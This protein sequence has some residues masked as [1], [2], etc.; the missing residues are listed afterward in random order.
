MAFKS[1]NTGS[2]LRD[3][4]VAPSNSTTT[5]STQTGV[6]RDA[7]PVPPSYDLDTD[8]PTFVDAAACQYLSSVVDAPGPATTEYLVWSTNT[9][10]LAGPIDPD[11]TW[12]SES[13]YGTIPVGSKT[14]GVYTDGSERAVVTDNGFRDIGRIYAIV[15]AR[16][17][18]TNYDDDGWKNPDDTNPASYSGQP[19]NGL[20]PFITL[21][22][23]E[24]EQ[25]ARLGVVYF[26]AEHL[27]ALGGGLSIQRGDKIVIV[28]YT[29]DSAKFWWTKN[30][31]YESRFGWVP[32]S[33][34]WEPFK[35]SAPVMLGVVLEDTTYNM[36]PVIRNLPI[37]SLL[38]GN[39]NVSD[40]Y[41]MVR[42]G[43]VPSASE[44]MPVGNVIVR[45]DSELGDPITT[46]GR[47]SQ[48]TGKLELSPKFVSTHR[49]KML[50]YIPNTFV[51]VN[52]GVIGKLTDAF[53]FIA[54]IPSVTEFPLIRFGSRR[55]LTPKMVT[56]DY[57]LSTMVGPQPGNVLVSAT[58]GKLKLSAA[59]VA[60]S[61]T[62]SLL[63][64][65]HFLGE[66]V[67]Y[68]GVSLSGKPQPV[69]APVQLLDDIGN[70]ATAASDEMYIPDYEYLPAEFSASNTRRGLGTSGILDA[71]DGT[72]ANPDKPG[73]HAPIRP[74]G[75]NTIDDTTGRVR[76]VGDGISDTI[77]FTQL[78]SIATTKV[79]NRLTDVPATYKIPSGTAYI[80][81]ER[82][83]H[84]SRVV[85]SDPDK[86][87][88]GTK[89]IFFL[90]SAFNPA[91]HTTHARLVS[92]NRAIFRLSGTEILRFAIDG[93]AHMWSATSLV[94][95][96]PAK[97]FFTATDIT[98]NI[99]MP[100][101][102]SSAERIIIE[103]PNLDS[104]S[105]EIGFG[106]G[107]VLDTSGCT[108]LGFVPG[109]RAV[110]GVDNWLP[111]SGVSIGMHR[112]PFNTNGLGGT[113]DFR[114]VD[115]V[116]NKIL[117]NGVQA[118]PFYFL[119]T[120]PLQDIA[121]IDDGVFFN[122]ST[123]VTIDDTVHAV[124]RNLIHYKDIVH[125][126]GH[127]KF[128][129]VDVNVVDEDIVA[130]TVTINFGHPGVIPESLESAV[131]G[132]LFVSKDGSVSTR[133]TLDVD[134][135][136]Q[137]GGLSGTALLTTKF[138][139]TKAYGAN[140]SILSNDQ[141]FSDPNSDFM[142]SGAKSGDIIVIG[143]GVHTVVDVVDPVTLYVTPPPSETQVGV[144]WD[145]MS[146][147]PDSVYDPAIVA[148]MSYTDFDH[149]LSE[150]MSIRILSPVD[151]TTGQANM[152][153]ALSSK[154]PMSIRFGSE[155]A[156]ATNT[157]GL[158]PLKQI[159][160]G[161]P[162][163]G[164]ILP[165]SQ[166]HRFDTVAFAIRA[167]NT[168]YKPIGVTNFS[169]DPTTIE[170]L[171]IA[172]VG[173]PCGTIK[174]GS[175]FL[176]S[177]SKVK[178]YYVETFLGRNF[179][180]Y[181]TA[182][183]D[184]LTGVINPSESDITI[185]SGKK[186]Y[187][188]EQLV[189]TARKDVAINPM[190]GAFSTNQQLTAGSLVE[191][192]YWQ[193]DLEGRKVGGQTTELLSVFVR[194][195]VAKPTQTNVYSFNSSRT[196]V[197]DQS[198]EPIVYIGPI[199]QNF[200]RLDYTVDYP[201]N[202]G[203]AGRITFVSHTVPNNVDVK[204][205]YSVFD[206]SGGERSFEVSKKPVY[207]PPFFIGANKD[208][209]GLRGNRVDE[210]M[211]GQLIR[212]GDECFYVKSVSYYQQNDKG[213]GDVTSV[214]I[215]PPTTNEVGSRAPGNDILTVITKHPITTMV[216]PDG[217]N[218]VS[219]TAPSG[220]MSAIDPS[221]LH[222]D[223]IVPGHKT[224][225]VHGDLSF[226]KPGRILEIGGI[227]YTISD[228]VVDET[229][230]RT[231]LT[232]TAS[233]RSNISADDE[234]TFKVSN[235]PV[236]P[237]GATDFLGV[238]PILHTDTNAVLLL[239][240]D[241]PGRVLT[242]DVDYT[243]NESTGDVSI[244]SGIG[245]N[246]KVLVKF[247]RVDTLAPRM[248]RGVLSVPRF[249]AMFLSQ[250]M[251]NDENGILG[252]KLAAT[253]TYYAP[254]SFYFRAVPLVSF[255]GEVVTEVTAEINGRQPAG[256][257]INFS[258]NGLKNWE[259][260][261]W[262]ILGE[263]RHLLD[264]DR[265]SRTFLEY[266]N[267]VIVS[268]EQ[269][270]ETI[271]GGF[272]GD[273]DGRFHFWIG[274]NQSWP[275]PGYEDPITG[276]LLSDNVWTRI[277]NQENP[278]SKYFGVLS[279]PIVDP[280][281][282]NVVDGAVVGTI[283]SSNTL[284][285]LIRKQRGLVS[286]DVDDIVL[287]SIGDV[288]VTPTI[289]SPF[290]SMS[291]TGQYMSMGDEHQLSR[292]FPT[293][294]KAII[295]TLPGIGDSPGVYTAGL[296]KFGEKMS[297][298]GDT[299]AIL[300][301]PIIGDIKNVSSAN[302]RKRR[303]RA[304][305]WG[306]FPH[307][308]PA[309]TIGANSA[310]TKPCI[311][312][313]QSAI[314][315]VRID[316]TTG[317][318]D[319]SKFLSQ[320]PGGVTPDTISG[321]PW[322]AIPGFVAGD[323]VALG[324]PNGTILPLFNYADPIV[325]GTSHTYTG[326]FVDQVLFGCVLTFKTAGG[327]AILDPHVIFAG[328]AS[329]VDLPPVQGDTIFVGAPTNS[330]SAAPPDPP[331]FSTFQTMTHG[332]DI[333]RDGFDVKVMA[334]GTVVDMSL[335]SAVDGTFLHLKEMF[336]Q[337]TPEPFGTLDGPVDFALNN[338]N[339]LLVPALT[340]GFQDDSGDF[341]IPYMLSANTEMDRFD[342]I[343]VSM[344]GVYSTDD[345]GRAVY[346]NEILANDGV[347][348]ADP[349]LNPSSV[350]TSV[351]TSPGFGPGD[352]DVRK[353][354][355]LLNQVQSTD[356]FTSAS[357]M[358]IHTIGYVE[359]GNPSLIEPPRF[360]TPTRPPSPGSTTTDPMRYV[361]ENA[362]VF[363]EGPYPAQPQAG[364]PPSGVY[365]SEDVLGGET[366]FD[367]GTTPIVLN[368]GET[369]G[370][371]NLNDVFN[372]GGVITIKLIARRDSDITNGP[373]GANPLPSTTPGG[374]VALTVDIRNGV[375]ITF[376][377]YQG[378]VYG[379]FAVAGTA[380]GTSVPPAGAVA[381]NKQ[382][383]VPTTGMIPWG[384]GAGLPNQWFLPHTVAAGPVYGM[385]YG[386]EYTF[387]I[388][389]LNSS[390]STTAWIS[391]DRLT[392]NE[393]YDLSMSKKRG[394]T[395]PQS[396]LD[397]ETK[398]SVTHVTVGFTDVTAGLSTVNR[399]GNNMVPY[400]MVPRTDQDT[401][402]YWSPRVGAITERGHLRV[403]GFEGV[404]NTPITGVDATFS[405]IPSNDRFAGGTILGGVGKTASGFSTLTDYTN[406]RFDHRVTE[407]VPSTGHDF[408]VNP[409]DVL[410]INGSANVD[411]PGSNQVGTY[412]V[413]H[414]VAA[415]AP[416]DII[417]KVS[418]D[419]YAGMGTGWCP[420]HFPTVVA[421]DSANHLLTMTDLAPAPDGPTYG[422]N[423]SGWA[424]PGVSTRVF[425][426]RDVGS[427]ASSDPNVFRYG[428]ISAK[429]TNITG[430]AIFTL[431]DYK[432]A[433]GNL[434]AGGS[435]EFG[436][437]LDKSYPVS[438]MTYWPINVSG[439]TYG[440]PDNNTVGYDSASSLPVPAQPFVDWAVYGFHLLSLIPQGP[441]S[442][443]STL[444]WT[445][446]SA[447][448]PGNYI[449][450]TPGVSDCIVPMP[451]SVVDQFAFQSDPTRA[452]YPWV[453]RT[454]D[455]RQIQHARWE[456]I[457][458]I[459]GSAGFGPGALIDCVL[460]GTKLAAHSGGQAGFYAQTGIFLEPSF[461]RSAV[462]L[463]TGHPRVVDATHSL[464]DPTVQS[465]W[466][467]EVGMRDSQVYSTT[468][469]PDFVSFHV[470]RIRRFHDVVNDIHKEVSPLRFAYEIRRGIVTGYS[471]DNK[472][473]GHVS[474]NGFAWTDGKTH[475]GTQLGG[476]DDHNVNINAG[477]IIRLIGADDIII[478]EVRITSITDSGSVTLSS[479]GFKTSVVV[480]KQFQIF[481]K[482]AP[483]PH[484]Q[485][486][487]ELLDI[488][489]DK[490]IAKTTADWTLQ[491]GGY[492]N[493]ITGSVAYVDS[494]N[495]LYDDLNANNPGDFSAM[496]VRK[497]D[498]VVID[499]TG[500]IP[501][502][503]GQPAIQEFGSRP[504]GDAGVP[505]R[506][507]A[508]VYVPGNPSSLDDNR[509]FYKVKQIV[510]NV[511]PPYLVVDPIN[512]FCGSTTQPVVYAP[513]PYSYSVYPTVTDSNLMHAP[514]PDPGVGNRKESQMALRPTLKRDTNTKSFV[515][516]TDGFIGHSIRP[517]SYRI[518]RPT[519]LFS[520]EAIDLV[521][522]MRERTQ[523]M[524][525]LIR[526]LAQGSKNGG[527][528]EFQRDGHIEDLGSVT[529]H[530]VGRGVP[531]NQFITAIG[532]RTDVTPYANN[533]GCLSILDRRVWIHDS[534]MDSLTTN[535]SGGMKTKG[536]GDTAYTAYTNINGSK[537]LPVLP[538]RIDEILNTKDKFR[539]LR[540]T[541]LSY[542]THKILGTL[543]AIRR[544]DDSVQSRL[545][546][547]INAIEVI[548]AAGGV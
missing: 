237:P 492:V 483:V 408:N 127:K 437:L 149:L 265:V 33:R 114:A 257:S 367:F 248:D 530:D 515:I 61:D 1:F 128:D 546:D 31:R 346:P 183:Y 474:A 160:I 244:A 133:L 385:L 455:V 214:N 29:V 379:P 78:G 378:I 325:V 67:I 280:Q 273:R 100:T 161:Y 391:D 292:L 508:G 523:S 422:G 312:A 532:G 73:V 47:M 16:G 348:V 507:D 249:T 144:V 221:I 200:G 324:R 52:D 531:S 83:A 205:S 254:D 463:S 107:G 399:H 55:Y 167:A 218:P 51:S 517:F 310:I 4:Q 468:S 251:P 246:Q 208:R 444:L 112:S 498:I 94:S 229:G 436:T 180:E 230:S 281:S 227:P 450:K 115:R 175:K 185:N 456:L 105:V 268:F 363:V 330:F 138:L 451:N 206:M 121:G 151:A 541:W 417:K 136:I 430:S 495:R 241:A 71:P 427:L 425:I 99:G 212:I 11:P 360:V 509:G 253:Y 201:D 63:F 12:W 216:D 42:V 511:S 542:R 395:H 132:G 545:T 404:N 164:I 298:N 220:L 538:D 452:V 139:P 182:E 489:T 95:A 263:R 239:D 473:N 91:T 435:V 431:T 409:G 327:A 275:T 490:K 460:P 518:I 155:P 470:R 503:G 371:G 53:L 85:L 141:T 287:V 21:H 184:P 26:S 27:A 373:P 162:S 30:D 420:L 177:W 479:P 129:W 179:V 304:H 299:I 441:L 50:W 219:T 309:N 336:G 528:F 544:F 370:V 256:G 328:N 222:F 15:V 23:S 442:T 207:R 158:L 28:H 380:F 401:V 240:S 413:R 294:T 279:D 429:Y 258:Q 9:A 383:R 148:D 485:S 20:N 159:E 487:E 352:G 34:R 170:F 535:P 36:N 81:R 484:E 350:T 524:I 301:N 238:G 326:V 369:I 418:L 297:T 215:F 210:F 331:E 445:G 329:V 72:G 505:N 486:N 187:F 13:G 196:H 130:P 116:E 142:S 343:S 453:V 386:L 454:L 172:G 226:A 82:S 419:T 499:P 397:L 274:H 93:I 75:D 410:V 443:G 440:L 126:F 266:Y 293:R 111:D 46:N 110:G 236:Y 372:A 60:K 349:A 400:T 402:G 424:T 68:D 353:Y 462:N 74:G 342:A 24:S 235:R 32:S 87:K 5:G 150:T 140:G 38:P 307:G 103:S 173:G 539:S 118:I 202:L 512:T 277:V 357:A 478:E 414:V 231:S 482:R 364:A 354:D 56:N 480:G 438:G 37:N 358:G 153:G 291:A 174:F 320:N 88:F 288:T 154:R 22:F 108:A 261:R 415:D 17:D 193:A 243:V 203:A 188:V 381:D 296:L 388:D 514:Y 317:Y 98:N 166:G 412:L 491:S 232:V 102:Y 355:L 432:D 89:P 109:W 41:S 365:V 303:A 305:I 35:G 199:R 252:G 66:D 472:Q 526:Q 384:P 510:D 45:P 333:Y 143:G 25:D 504:I 48:T 356:P 3:S 234:P 2:V 416:G 278:T 421:F 494:V 49:G 96:N 289:A 387:T 308:I 117:V 70:P 223:P 394:Y 145:L 204:V 469:T 211:A 245:S 135:E 165:I 290:I 264:K 106:V 398:L 476:F 271:S 195:E 171:T 306:W 447:A 18:I 269:I 186:L 197:I 347:I 137:H 191:V 44:S 65:K 527:Y 375:G 548:K 377:D 59:D 423:P 189:T 76:Q 285:K 97:L 276:N 146:G 337:N 192:S 521:L 339:P 366:I 351:P 321:D 481:L 194:N 426:I 209:F 522:T 168:Q 120:V 39:Q 403:M 282:I 163:N 247:T 57:T 345:I 122:L 255:V 124:D 77:L 233:F 376:T 439:S 467:R 411:H 270:N 315:D 340:G 543:A 250:Q 525:E 157:A 190:L 113:P 10:N 314:R 488:I 334:D 540:Y 7:R 64:N 92:R 461:P 262:D 500:A 516:R 374:V 228:S 475:T 459:V 178:I 147:F 405:A 433:L 389:T 260:G 267:N 501:K 43:A 80:V 537:V 156:T 119:N 286:N 471:V 79:V 14:I 40:A 225:V 123:N 446:D 58:T 513:N 125:R 458:V 318:P 368:N 84:G 283:V 319:V 313:V 300:R 428:V 466:L 169:A 54:P 519:K 465:D 176:A 502:D 101:V 382:I 547:Q 496:G 533:S 8:A 406:D 434:L 477:D 259:N 536:P 362:M 311:V 396:S 181:G 302:L 392:F 6:V 529:D 213:T 359:S 332:L 224:V 407:I 316:P 341:G 534:R 322:L 497:G 323:Q 272:V 449:I 217:I 393:V 335:P 506:L 493:D 464:P 284:T 520:A 62:N 390:S 69:R 19:R 131:G 361:V 134:Y 198:V 448:A 86:S 152:S 104:G 295:R 242:R 457:N 338:Q 90:Q 344:S